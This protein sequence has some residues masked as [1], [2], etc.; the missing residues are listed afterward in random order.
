MMITK[1]YL[2]RR[3]VLRGLGAAL[4]L[5][6]L[7]S[8]TPAFAGVRDTAAKAVRRLGV[9]YVPMG[10]NMAK[11]TPPTEGALELTPI[12]EPL[13]SFRDRLVVVS[14]LDSQEGTGNDNGPHP[15]VQ[16]AWLTGARARQTD[17][18]D[19]RAGVS[20]DQIA[21]RAFANETQFASLELA[22]EAVDTP[23]GGCANFGYSCAYSSTIA[24]ST[25]TTPLPMEFNPRA[26]FERLFGT[27]ASTDQR[28]RLAQIQR[29]RSLLDAVTEKI[30]RLEKRIGPG[31]RAKLTQYLDA[32][33]DVERSI[34]KAEE[35]VARELP[36]VDRPVGVPATFE[37][38]AK[39]MY[40]LLALAYQCDMTRVFT[41]LYGREASIRSFP[42]IGVSDGWHPV[43]HHGDNPVQLEKQAKI[44]IYHMKMF[45]YFLEKLRST[46]DGDGSLLDHTT[47]LYGSGMSDS[48]RHMPL[49]LPT[50]IVGGPTADIK[51]GRHIRYPHGTPL[52]NLHV[53]LLEK[54]GVPAEHLGDSTGELDLLSGI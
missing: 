4:A 26:V 30:A 42:E 48:Q 54:V 15:R 28:T 38:H 33:R 35:Q 11:W 6:L 36:V 29:N 34:Q 49:N 40:D 32:V 8:M 19:I 37:E 45:A 46:A 21:A 23:N 16:A 22:L 18:I 24:W 50:L 27:S 10:M 20:M 3:T 31:D 47:I 51:G 17:G 44:N 14:G 52:A 41:F 1:K 13:A 7:D 12:L 2:P 5:P 25:P 39:L 43:S 9:I 53:T